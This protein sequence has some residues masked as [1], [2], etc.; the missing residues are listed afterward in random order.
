LQLRQQ[1][2]GS[3]QIAGLAAGEMKSNRV[4]QGIDGGVDFGA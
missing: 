4:T 1:N 2:I 3:F